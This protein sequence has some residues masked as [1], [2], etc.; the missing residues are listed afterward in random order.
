MKMLFN[1]LSLCGQFKDPIDFLCSGVKPFLVIFK[2][3]EKLSVELLKKSDTWNRNVTDTCTLHNI[4]ISPIRKS[5]ELLRLKLAISKLEKEPFWDNNSLQSYDVSYSL[6]NNFD[7]AGSS[8]AEAC[9]RDK[10]IISFLLS[11]VSANPLFV[12]KDDSRITLCNFIKFGELTE[13][14]WQRREI[15]F[16]Q[17]LQSLF[18]KSKLNFSKVDLKYGFDTIQSNEQTAFIGTFKKFQTMSWDDIY[19]DIGLDYKQ[20]KGSLGQCHSSKTYKFRVS[21]GMRCHGSRNGDQFVVIGFE[22]DHK[23]SDKG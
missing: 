6:S 3:M 11:P 13:R 20:Y 22:R 23:L 8:I 7:V 17:Y 16:S 15:S 21:E 18:S 2:E 5:D 19:K 12:F 1:E 4:L 10:A 14:L 9:H